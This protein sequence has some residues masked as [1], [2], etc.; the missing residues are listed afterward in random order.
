MVWDSL[1]WAAYAVRVTL[2]ACLAVGL[3]RWEPVE[4]ATADG[5]STERATD[6]RLWTVGIRWENDTFADQDQFYTN[7]MALSLAHTGPSWV[8]PVMDWLPWYQG[9]RTVTYSLSQAMFTPEDT[10][11]TIPDPADRPYAGVLTLDLGLHV[12]R[13][14]R[15]HGLKLA[16]GVVGPWAGAGETQRAIHRLIGSD[17]PQGWD[18]QLHNEPVINLVYEHRRKYRLW[19]RADGWAAEVI[20]VAG[21]ALGN[22]LIEGAV[23]GEV[24]LGYKIPDDFGLS[25]LRGM[26]ALPPP[27][28]ELTGSQATA[29]STLGFYLFGGVGANF[30]LRDLTLDGNTFKDSA[31][32][33]KEWFVPVGGVGVGVGN[34]HFLATFLYVFSGKTFQGQRNAAE[35][36]ALTLNFFF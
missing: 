10:S 21:C 6:A 30:V 33:D 12:E 1:R 18:A 31:S 3:A 13:D 25:L 4:A 20:P 9:R 15:Y 8:D 16:L 19:G 27:R 35:Y 26:S 34:R 28:V 29:L 17:K 7:G 2:C 14:N 32:V 11:R 24:R 5:L 36:G 22:L 23:A